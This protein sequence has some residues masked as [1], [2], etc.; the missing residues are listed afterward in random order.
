MAVR[1]LRVRHR[2]RILSAAARSTRPP[3]KAMPV[4]TLTIGAIR[5]TPVT[6]GAFS[7]PPQRFLPN[8]PAEAWEGERDALDAQGSIPLN[9]GS[10]LIDEGGDLTL[11]DTGIG[12][13]SQIPNSG[14]LLGALGQ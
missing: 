11:V 8:V 9:L 14:K 12:P 4:P 1:R 7:V 10:F 2:V 5:I 13:G 6:D 3:E